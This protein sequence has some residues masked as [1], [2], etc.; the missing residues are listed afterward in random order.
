MARCCQIVLGEMD[1]GLYDGE[2]VAEVSELVVLSTVALQ[3]GGGIPVVEVGDGAAEGME[4][5]GWSDEEGL[6]P[7]RERLGDVRR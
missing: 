7:T 4:G 6:E 5:W 3:L 1:L 2:L